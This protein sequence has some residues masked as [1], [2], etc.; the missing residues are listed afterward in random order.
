MHGFQGINWGQSGDSRA[1]SRG[2]LGFLTI[3]GTGGHPDL[4]GHNQ[5]FKSIDPCFMANQW[6]KVSDLAVSKLFFDCLKEVIYIYKI[7]NK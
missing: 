2:N 5:L 7:C 6:W 1:I 4:D 3:Q